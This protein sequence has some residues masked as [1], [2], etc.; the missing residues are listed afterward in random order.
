MSKRVSQPCAEPRC[1]EGVARG[2][3]AAHARERDQARGTAAER[4]YDARWQ[5]RRA[6]YLAGHRWCVDC[7][8]RATEVDHER[9]H[10]GDAALFWDEGNWRAR[11]K[12]CHSRKTA[13][14]DGGFG[15]VENK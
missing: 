13:L 6:A 2:R 8:A 1:F 3:C 7:G 15:R 5:A 11:C 4:G 9:A 12:G 10:R 14:Q